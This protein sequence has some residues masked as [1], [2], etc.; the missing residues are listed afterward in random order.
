[1]AYQLLKIVE[2]VLFKTIQF[3]M[4]TQ[5]VKNISISNYP[6]Y[7]SRLYNISVQCKYSLNVKKQFYFK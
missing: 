7:S 1:M 4:S 6:V 3:S 5:F 2:S